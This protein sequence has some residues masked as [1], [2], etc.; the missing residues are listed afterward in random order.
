MNF[1]A[2]LKHTWS[3]SAKVSFFFNA[4]CKAILYT[5]LVTVGGVWFSIAILHSYFGFERLNIGHR[6]YALLS[7]VNLQSSTKVD[8]D[9][10]A[11]T[12]SA[13]ATRTNPKDIETMVGRDRQQCLHLPQSRSG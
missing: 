10:R 7:M 4:P 11:V 9:F 1:K 6:L 2:D 12:A 3:S 13:N 5:S 8:K